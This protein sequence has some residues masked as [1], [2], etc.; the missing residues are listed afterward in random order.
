MT[1]IYELSVGVFEQ[2]LTFREGLVSMLQAYL[3]KDILTAGTLEEALTAAHQLADAELHGVFVGEFDAAHVGL[4]AAVASV[5]FARPDVFAIAMVS[6]E[7]KE[8]KST[9]ADLKVAYEHVGPYIQSLLIEISRYS[10]R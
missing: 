3:H 7:P 4:R 8:V 2:D 10:S 9:G 5:K 6:G 1:E